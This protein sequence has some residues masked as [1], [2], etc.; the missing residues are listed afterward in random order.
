MP[1]TNGIR[2]TP[3][4]VVPTPP[5]LPIVTS[6]AATTPNAPSRRTV[7]ARVIAWNTPLFGSTAAAGNIARSAT[8]PAAYMIA[9]K[10]PEPTI[11]GG[12]VLRGLRTSSLINEHSSRP[13]YANAICGQKFTVF[14]FQVGRIVTQVNCVA[15]PCTCQM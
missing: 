11:A 6:T 10:T 2:A 1:T 4:T 9:I 13:V 12:N 8:V 3:A 7:D 14:Q 15:E 5:A